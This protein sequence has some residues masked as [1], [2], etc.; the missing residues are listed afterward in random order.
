MAHDRDQQEVL[1]NVVMH[2]SS[3]AFTVILMVQ[4]YRLVT[5][6]HCVTD[7]PF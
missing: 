5:L 7:F 2:A 3:E 4:V 1:V 6:C